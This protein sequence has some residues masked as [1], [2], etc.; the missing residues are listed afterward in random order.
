MRADDFVDQAWI[1]AMVLERFLRFFDVRAIA[2]PRGACCW[3]VEAPPDWATTG[4]T[5]SVNTNMTAAKVSKAS[6]S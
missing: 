2:I 4:I 6:S 5:M 1:V 3:A